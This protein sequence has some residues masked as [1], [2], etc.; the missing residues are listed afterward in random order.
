[1]TTNQH[2]YEN[3]TFLLFVSNQRICQSVAIWDALGL[4]ERLRIVFGGDSAWIEIRQR[5]AHDPLGPTLH[6]IFLI[7]KCGRARSNQRALE[8]VAG[9]LSSSG[10]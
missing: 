7:R 4:N 5:L 6:V 3:R 1:M 2:G 9:P 8:R 10:P